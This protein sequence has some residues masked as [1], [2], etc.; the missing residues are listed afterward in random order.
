M[1]LV[2]SNAEV[3]QGLTQENVMQALDEAYLDLDQ[4]LTD[5]LVGQLAE[6]NP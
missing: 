6:R 3:E 4:R 5:E 1:V 2:I